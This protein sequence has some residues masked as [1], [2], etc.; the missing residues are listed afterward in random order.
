MNRTKDGRICDNRV[1][2]PQELLNQILLNCKKINHLTWEQFSKK[3]DISSYTIRHDWLKKGNTIP[4]SCLKDMLDLHPKLEWGR[5]KKNVRIL[6]PYWGQK[7]GKKSKF[8]ILEM[9]YCN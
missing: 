2:V 6:K 1:R 7:I 8:S 4:L 9:N 5:I 3:L